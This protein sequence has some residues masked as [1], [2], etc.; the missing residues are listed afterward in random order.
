MSTLPYAMGP[1]NP[2][3]LVFAFELWQLLWY[4][5]EIFYFVDERTCFISSKKLSAFNGKHT[6]NGL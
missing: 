6:S 3:T 2:T 1:Q 4:L 5:H